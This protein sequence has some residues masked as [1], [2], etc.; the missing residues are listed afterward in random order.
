M[1]AALAAPRV[2][3]ATQ[4]NKREYGKGDE[5]HSIEK[6]EQARYDPNENA[7]LIRESPVPGRHW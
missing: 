2:R 6:H 3:S 5:P 1:G 7:L 4:T